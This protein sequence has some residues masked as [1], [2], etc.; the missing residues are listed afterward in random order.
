MFITEG[1]QVLQEGI[2][3][4]SET[5]NLVQHLKQGRSEQDYNS[6]LTTL[7]STCVT[8]F[9]YDNNSRKRWEEASVSALKL[10]MS[11]RDP[12]TFP[13][14]NCSNINLPL[15]TIAALQFQARAYD[16]LI[17]PK[18]T[19]GV[20]ATGDEDRP[21]AER[22]RRYMNYQILYK[23]EDFEEGMDKTLIQLPVIGCVFRKTFYDSVKQCVSSIYV[24]SGDMVV[25]YDTKVSIEECP[26]KTHVIY[27]TEN[28]CKVRA[29]KGIFTPEAFT[30]GPGETFISN[31]IKDEMDNVV[32]LSQTYDSKDKPRAILEQHGWW[33]LDEDGIK[34]PYVITVDYVTQKVLRITDRR[35]VERSGKVA[36]IEYFTKYGFIPNPEGFYDLGLGILLTNLNESAN[37]IINEVIDA[38]QLANLQGGF[39]S[40]KSGLKKGNLTFQMGEYKEVDIYAEDLSKSIMHLDF[41]GPN[42]TLYAVLGLIYEYSKLV[43]SVSETMTGQLPASDTPY[44]SVIAVLEEGRKVFSTIH[45]RIHRSFKKELKK[46]YRLNSIYLDEIEYF[47]VLGSNGIPTSEQDTVGR[48]DFISSIDVI[49][50]SDPMIISRAEKIMRAQQIYQLIV[51]NPLTAQNPNSVTEAMRRF[52]D[53][54]DEPEIEKLLPPPPEPPDLK[55]EEENAG[56]LT[57]NPMTVL[58][59]QDHL[60]HLRVHDELLEGT[61]SSELTPAGN[62]LVI[63]HRQQHIS[64]LY[65]AQQQMLGGGGG[66]AR[67]LE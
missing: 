45:K 11:F 5:I 39:I 56:F 36:I 60:H 19:V 54:L 6:F 35:Y 25:N 34:E 20:V 8:D 66:N 40:K 37:T 2:P 26:R 23:M 18:G 9:N 46:I 43:S 4:P 33:D 22:V 67:T 15:L 41:K 49:P 48:S 59:H 50:V 16:A 24:S 38:G 64:F 57:E 42:Q 30:L 55:P 27:L 51:Q 47:N 12:K 7:G 21:K 58:S 17:N 53:A 44:S 62:K 29:V 31:P 14:R 63:Q 65:L 1:E 3:V 32:G 61:F 28:D 52:I 10:F 13:W